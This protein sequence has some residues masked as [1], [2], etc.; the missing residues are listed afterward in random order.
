MQM[1]KQSL[2]EILMGPLLDKQ[3]VYINGQGLYTEKVQGKLKLWERARHGKYPRL[4]GDF[5]TPGSLL[6]GYLCD[7]LK[8]SFPDAT[9]EGFRDNSDFHLEFVHD[10]SP[11]SLDLV[12]ERLRSDPRNQYYFFSDD[13]LCKI[14]GKVY[15]MD[16]SS[17]DASQTRAIFDCVIDA[18]ADYPQFQKYIRRNV[19]QCTLPIHLRCARRTGVRVHKQHKVKLRPR[20]PIESS[21]TT[22]T[23]ALNNFASMAIALHLQ[24]TTPRDVTGVEFRAAQVGYKVTVAERYSLETVQFLKHSFYF[25]GERTHS[26]LNLGPVLRSFGT[27]RGDLPGNGPI[28]H[29]ADAWNAAVAKGYIH[30]GLDDLLAALTSCR[31]SARTAPLQPRA[32]REIDTR[33]MRE[34]GHHFSKSKRN[35]VPTESLCE[36]YS[37][38]PSEFDDLYDLLR[39]ADLSDGSAIVN[40]PLVKRIF[41]RDYG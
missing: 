1:R 23:T 18:F 3:A 10:I 27:C 38:I 20:T 39:T 5:S 15:E 25:D 28:A 37:A 30:S 35:R 11:E 8:K 34:L 21:G 29:R 32:Y 4:I 6:G 12:G 2:F 24:A 7:I 22:L 13:N 26:F 36:R 41:L 40:L 31:H 16:I 33:V 14:N 19:R 17:C 9:Q